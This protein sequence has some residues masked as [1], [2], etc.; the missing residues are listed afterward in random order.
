MF[1]KDVAG[2]KGK[3][4]RN[5]PKHVASY[6][7]KIPKETL[8]KHRNVYL[9][10]DTFFVN[11]ITFFLSYSRKINYTGVENLNNR[12]SQTT[13]KAFIAIYKVY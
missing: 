2:L 5:K 1:G 10:A 9:T 11:E 12:K 13:F 4:T 8:D 3:A 6:R 7:L